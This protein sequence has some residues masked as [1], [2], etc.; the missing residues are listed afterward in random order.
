[1]AVEERW[2]SVRV[3]DRWHATY[4]IAEWPRVDVGADFLSPLL[5]VGGARTVSV[6]M[7]PVPPDRALREVHS[8]RTAN[9]A[10][11]ELRRR[12]GFLSTAHHRREAEGALHRE[13]ELADGHGDY[14][15]CGYVSVG[16]P[17]PLELDAACAELE[18]AAQQ[19]HLELRRLHG[20]QRDALSWTMPLGRGLS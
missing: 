11:A 1:M 5:L 14:R 10:D 18:Q 7:A 13:T 8:A 20:Q 9:M 19:S 15:F 16:A 12:A 6:T 4:W 3:D 2:S 17:S